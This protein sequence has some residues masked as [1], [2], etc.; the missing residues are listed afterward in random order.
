MSKEM[1]SQVGIL[2]DGAIA[3]G[4]GGWLQV[5]KGTGKRT[6]HASVAGTG[7]VSATV[8]IHVSNDESNPLTLATITLSGTNS[9]KDGF[10]FD[11]PW[12]N[13]RAEVTAISGTDAA[14]T[15]TMGV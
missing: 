1:Q 9:D 10:T 15:T 5:P 12:P 14:V 2:L 4:A 13:V 6:I 11:A 3:A 7:A 8:E